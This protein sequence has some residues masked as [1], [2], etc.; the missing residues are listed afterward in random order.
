[1][2]SMAGGLRLFERNGIWQCRVPVSK[3]GRR[4]YIWRSLKTTNR[5]EAQ[6]RAED[7]QLEVRFAEKFGRSLFPKTVNQLIDEWLKT[8]DLTSAMQVA[9]T[10]ALRYWKVYIGNQFVTEV[11]DLS[12]YVKWRR[13]YWKKHQTGANKARKKEPADRTIVFELQTM[14]R[15]FAFAKKKG[16]I[17]ETV[18]IPS[19]KRVKANSRPALPLEEQFKLKAHLLK[20]GF[21]PR[22]SPENNSL[23]AHKA[24]LRALI[25]T[26]LLS[27]I[28][29]GE[30][31][32]LKWSDIEE[33]ELDNGRKTLI[34]NVAGKT[35]RH[36]AIARTSLHRHLHR[37][38]RW[39]EISGF[40][41]GEKSH[42]FLDR[43]GKT[44]GDLRESF[45]KVCK[46]AGIPRYSLYSLRHTFIT[47]YLTY[48]TNVDLYALAKSCGTSVAMIERFYG[49]VATKDRIRRILG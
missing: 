19:I 39:L 33:A 43:Y 29:V 41:K 2:I 20:S 3:Q 35:G 48:S 6:R 45:Q 14:R 10:K 27:G 24:M 38:R 15:V 7:W 30:A 5:H 49:H 28:R 11:G 40:F 8:E 26:L 23:D 31:R 17:G 25:L 9:C 34:L 44:I 16:Y 18:D 46:E 13:D 1:M 22:A 36:G 4:R 32:N 42:V 47:N 37:Y 12:D 21:I